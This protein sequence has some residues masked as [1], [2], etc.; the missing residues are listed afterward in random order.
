YTGTVYET[1]FNDYPEIGSVCSGGRYDNLASE[2]TARKLPGVGI[3]IGLSRLFDQFMKKGLIATNTATYTQAFVVAMDDSDKN[4]ALDLVNQLRSAG[5]P[6]EIDTN[7]SRNLKKRMKYADNL[8]IPFVMLVG[9]DEVK[10]N[11]YS[12]KN[13]I[14]GDESKNLDIAQVIDLVQRK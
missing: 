11:T 9:E 12:V 8:K 7:T 1:R 2:Y 14:T 3:S 5:I 13:Y 4:Y 10:A 6:S